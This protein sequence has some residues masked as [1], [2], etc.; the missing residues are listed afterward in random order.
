AFAYRTMQRS[1]SGASRARSVLL[2]RREGVHVKVPDLSGAGAAVAAEVPAG[3]HVH[4]PVDG[5]GGMAPEPHQRGA[6][7]GQLPPGAVDQVEA[8]QV[9]GRVLREGRP[10]PVLASGYVAALQVEIGPEDGGRAIVPRRID[11]VLGRGYVAPPLQ[12][13]VV[14]P[15]VSESDEAE[16]R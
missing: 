10:A 3:D 15:R 13:Q 7:P 2:L 1:S 8:P 11:V 12:H 9:R 6:T 14:L 5:S 16:V 4:L